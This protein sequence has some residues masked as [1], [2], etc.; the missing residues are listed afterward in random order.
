V[1]SDRVLIGVTAGETVVPI[2]EGQLDAY[3]VGRAYVGMVN[4]VGGDAVLLPAPEEGIKEAASRLLNRIDGLMLS[5]GV[6]ISP[7]SYGGE[8]EPA[9]KPEPNRDAFE[10]ELVRGAI[11]RDI[12]VLGVCRGMQMINVALGGTLHQ[13][14]E[15]SEVDAVEDH[16]FRGIRRHELELSPGSRASQALG[17]DQVEVMCL[18]HQ[19]PDRIGSG[20]E[21]T[22]RASDG[23]IEVVET[24]DEDG[25]CLGVLW[26]PEH[27]YGQEDLQ[28]RLYGALVEAANRRL[29]RVGG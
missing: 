9:Q 15:H 4:R 1:A 24:E 2:I 20:L 21:V 10:A 13:H 11:D 23:I 27:M 28:S 19:S 5:G 14:V 25:F 26:H 16:G 3:Y 6:D 29:E 12:P 18:H 17:C 22:A 7:E 8:W